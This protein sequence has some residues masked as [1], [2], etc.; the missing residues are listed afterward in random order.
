MPSSALH[1]MRKSLTNP[2]HRSGAGGG[3]GGSG[4]A[5]SF[6]VQ[7]HI[8]TA[9]MI[10]EHRRRRIVNMSDWASSLGRRS[11]APRGAMGPGPR[12]L[13]S[14]RLGGPAGPGGFGGEGFAWVGAD[15]DVLAVCWRVGGA[16]DAGVEVVFTV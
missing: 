12:W 16:V 11:V 6:G 14:V 9:S 13:S 7:A 4:G 5:E 1:C 3:G 15:D 10:T 8:N 2:A